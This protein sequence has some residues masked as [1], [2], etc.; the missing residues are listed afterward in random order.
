MAKIE[1]INSRGLECGLELCPAE[2][3]LALRL[4]YR[5]QRCGEWINIAMKDIS[6]PR[7]NTFVF[8]VGH[9]SSSGRWV[10]TKSTFH[11]SADWLSNDEF[12]F[13]K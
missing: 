3:A 7:G 5:N 13:M 12:I 9:T 11:H 2:V 1:G 6:V 10:G 4:A 8:Q